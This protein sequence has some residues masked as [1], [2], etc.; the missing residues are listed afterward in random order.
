MNKPLVCVVSGEPVVSTEILADGF[1]VTHQ[2]VLKLVEKY[3]K[4]FQEI[5]TFG[6]E[7]QKSGGR[8]TK[9][10]N[11]TEEQAAFLGT[12]LRNNEKTVSFKRK[13]TKEFFRLR[14]EFMLHLAVTSTA[15]WNA[16]RQAGK[17]A[18]KQETKTIKTFSEYASKQGSKNADKYYANLS[19][20]KNKALFL[21]ETAIKKNLRECLNLNQLSIIEAADLIVVKALEDG[22]GEG[23]HY[24]AIYQLAK[25]RVEVFAQSIGKT[26]IPAFQLQ[27]NQPELLEA[28]S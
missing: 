25:E 2:A 10:F 5:K 24:K 22:M 26:M 20:M 21:L 17:I 7:I 6:F 3:Q 14:K 8:N 16:K 18:R 13:L 4:D 1:G 12:L 11:L 23:L 19:T 27:G 15:E 9:F 28:A